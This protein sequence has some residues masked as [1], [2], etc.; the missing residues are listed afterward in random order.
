MVDRANRGQ[1][2]YKPHD[3]S[4]GIV[5]VQF[6]HR[7]KGTWN[8]DLKNQNSDHFKNAAIDYN[9]SYG[10]LLNG[11]F[12]FLYKGLLSSD[13]NFWKWWHYCGAYRGRQF[14]CFPKRSINKR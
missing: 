4:R 9:N 2:P 10:S 14:F 12:T 13:H 5:A 1:G 8:D 3:L 7:H 6:E 11:R